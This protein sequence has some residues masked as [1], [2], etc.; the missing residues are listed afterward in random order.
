MKS[1]RWVVVIT[2]ALLATLLFATAALAATTIISPANLQGWGFLQ[3][4]PTGSGAL[5]AGPAT[6]PLGSG[7]AQIVVDSTGGE[8]L[9]KN[10][11]LGLQLSDITSLQY[12]TYRTAGGPALAIAL[13]L[14][15]DHDDTDANTGFQGRLVYEPYHTQPVYTGMWQTWNA[16][17]DNAGTGTGNWWFTPGSG[18]RPGVGVCPQSNPC[19]WAEVLAAFPNA[20]IHQTLGAVVLKAGGGWTGGF[21]GNVDALT[22]NGDTYNFELTNVAQTKDD[23]KNNGWKNV[24]DDEGNPFKN[25]G[26]C[27]QFVNTG[28]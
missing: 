14:N 23:C 17:D 13:Q 2:S 6:P 19:T 4:T 15:I 25:Q 18:F 16:L 8:I 22:I 12:S 21:D 24:T 5:V 11:Y 26:D 9:A 3:E 10:D 20:A 27:I 7:S 28:K 1:R